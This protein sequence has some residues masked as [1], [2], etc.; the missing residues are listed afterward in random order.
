STI[1]EHMP[2]NHQYQSEKMNP[3]RLISWGEN[4][5]NDAKEFVERILSEAQ[6]PV[7][8]YR[9]SGRKEFGHRAHSHLAS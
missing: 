2:L 8:A 4:I 7:K 6:Y 3:Q 9:M 5:G 1:K